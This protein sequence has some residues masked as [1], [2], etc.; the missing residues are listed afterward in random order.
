MK[1]REFLVGLVGASL[2]HRSANAQPRVPV[3]GILVTGS[4]DPHRS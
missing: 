3:I 2:W 4:R 1:R